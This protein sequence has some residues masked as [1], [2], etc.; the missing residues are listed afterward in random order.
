[1]KT[2]AAKP[3]GLKKKK[4]QKLKQQMKRAGLIKSPARFANPPQY[5]A[6]SFPETGIPSAFALFP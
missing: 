6:K 5:W 3:R 4:Q 2:R 1:M